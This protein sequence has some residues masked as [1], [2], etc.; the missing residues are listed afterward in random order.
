M[1]DVREN[2]TRAAQCAR[3]NIGDRPEDEAPRRQFR[4]IGD[5][6][7][8]QIAEVELAGLD[9]FADRILGALERPEQGVADIAANLTR[10]GCIVREGCRNGLP[11]CFGSF[12]T[13][14]GGCTGPSG[15]ASG[16]GDRLIEA[17][18]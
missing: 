3:Q 4:Q 1:Q 16:L 8:D 18:G 5:H 13:L 6:R 11:A 17:V 7:D 14:G 12:G 2:P 9:E 15:G 10:L